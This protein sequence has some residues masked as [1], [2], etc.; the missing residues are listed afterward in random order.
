[1]PGYLLDEDS[2]ARL[3]KMLRDYEQGNL[4]DLMPAMRAEYGTVPIVNYVRCTGTATSGTYPG[5]LVSY[6]S[7]LAT[8]TDT[9]AVRLVDINGGTLANNTRYLAR[10]AGR[11]SGGDPLY[12]TDS[13][14]TSGG[15]ILS[16]DVVTSIS[17]VDGAITPVWTTIC[18]P[19]GYVCNTT[20]TTTSTTTTAA[21]TTTT[22][23]TG[24]G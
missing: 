23:T 16:I 19:G 15:A 1:M 11:T 2:I 12:I 14:S 3:A 22:T 21:P 24:G 9:L 18:I 20:T 13:S 17:C 10:Y 7:I 4:G 8:Y 5:Q 6:D